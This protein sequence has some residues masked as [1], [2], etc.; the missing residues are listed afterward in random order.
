MKKIFFITFLLIFLISVQPLK[1]TGFIIYSMGARAAALAGA[2]VARADDASALSFNPA[3][4]AFLEGFRVKTNIQF[5]ALKASALPSNSQITFLSEPLQIQGLHYMAWSPIKNITFGFGRFIPYSYETEWNGDWP[6]NRICVASRFSTFYHRAAVAA[7]LLPGLAL[8]AGV[9]VV[10][11]RVEWNHNVDFPYQSFLYTTNPIYMDS[12]IHARGTGIGFVS[13]LLW[14]PGKRF[15]IGG[16]YQHKVRFDSTGKDTFHEPFFD[17]FTQTV[18]GPDGL[19]I[20]I[21]NLIRSFYQVQDVTF[22]TTLPR[23]VVVGLMLLPVDRLKLLLDF[24][25]TKWSEAMN[26]E[27]RSDKSGGDLSPE[28]MELYADFFGITPDYGVQGADLSWKDIWNIKFGMEFDISEALCIRAGY[29]NHPSAVKDNIIHPVVPDLN[30]NIISFGFG[31]SGPL[32]SI[33]DDSKLNDFSFDIFVQYMMTEEKIS[34]IPGYEF[35][36]GA[37]RLVIGLGMGFV[38]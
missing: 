5:G 13:G 6:G 15:Q 30:R 21:Y 19:R 31:Y 27:F 2:F 9:D 34:A 28:F 1:A 38:F 35:T 22:K 37:D 18:I 3:G 4:L 32:F 20:P 7:E 36:Y 11:S 12:R 8:G 23:D 26:W 14:K 33:W 16:K 10:L 17:A 25:W 24:Q 29:A